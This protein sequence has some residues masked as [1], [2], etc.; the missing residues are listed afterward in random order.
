MS[1]RIYGEDKKDPFHLLFTKGVLQ[2]KTLKF[3]R[4]LVSRQKQREKSNRWKH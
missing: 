2:R 4:H 3:Q 1:V